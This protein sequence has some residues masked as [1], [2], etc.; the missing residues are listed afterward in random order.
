[1]SPPHGAANASVEVSLN[2]QQFTTSGVA[3]EYYEPVRVSHVVPITGPLGGG[4][5]LTVHAWGGLLARH[6]ST[7]V[8]TSPWSLCCNTPIPSGASEPTGSVAGARVAALVVAHT[9]HIHPV[10]IA[11]AVH[12]LRHPGEGI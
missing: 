9:A 11:T 1:M 4:T 7:R 5:E 2:A 10:P 8:R 6:P 3:F 12:L